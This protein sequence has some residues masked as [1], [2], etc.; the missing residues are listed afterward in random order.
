M[1][2]LAVFVETNKGVRQVALTENQRNTI[3]SV[4]AMNKEKTI[5]VLDRDDGIEFAEDVSVV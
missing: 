4:C 2:K 1:L 3:L 5:S